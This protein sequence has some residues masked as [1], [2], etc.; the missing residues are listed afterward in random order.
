[1]R[2]SVAI[3]S[4]LV[5]GGLLAHFVLQDP[6]YVALSVGSAL[7]ETTV[8]VFGLLLAGLYVLVRALVESLG[9]RRRLA[10][11]R[12]RRRRRRARDETQRGLLALAAGRWRS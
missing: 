11:L 6:G 10:E 4:A 2:G 3:A 1:M 12:A 5:G 8:P 7:F 9:S